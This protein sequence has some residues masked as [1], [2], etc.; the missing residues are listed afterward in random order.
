MPFHRFKLRGGDLGDEY[1]CVVHYV[2]R[3]R[4]RDPIGLKNRAD[5]DKKFMAFPAPFC[6]VDVGGAIIT[7]DG[8]CYVTAP[9]TPSPAEH[10][11]RTLKRLLPLG[12]PYPCWPHSETSPGCCIDRLNPPG[13]SFDAQ[14]PGE[15][16]H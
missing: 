6:P 7:A 12:A 5:W 10:E 16:G 3:A 2:T 4:Q 14:A 11:W 1:V 15:T 9:L 8:I 13:L